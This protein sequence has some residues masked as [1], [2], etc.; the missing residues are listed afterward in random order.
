METIYEIHI[1]G[2]LPEGWSDWFAGLEI[3]HLPGGETVLTG[4]LPDQ[5]ALIGLLTRIQAWNMKL[6]SV[7]S[8]QLS[9]GESRE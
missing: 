1:T 6:L 2:H 3:R 7:N 9:V 4:P 8:Y 5:A